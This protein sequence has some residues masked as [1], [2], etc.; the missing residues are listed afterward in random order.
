MLLLL[1]VL[2]VEGPVVG[3]LDLGWGVGLLLM[4]M[5]VGLWLLLE[6]NVDKGDG[7]G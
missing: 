2:I 1:L 4:V 3:G 5:L 6:G 7:K